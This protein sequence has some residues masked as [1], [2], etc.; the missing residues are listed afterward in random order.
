VSLSDSATASRDVKRSKIFRIFSRAF[1]EA[2]SKD[3]LMALMS[4]ANDGLDDDDELDD[5]R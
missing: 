2:P 3:N 1:D 4:S 5:R